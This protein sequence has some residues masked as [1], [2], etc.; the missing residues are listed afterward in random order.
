MI[1]DLDSVKGS[2]SV[3]SAP[4]NT[5]RAH[6]ILPA[7]RRWAKPPLDFGLRNAH[8]AAML[9]VRSIWLKRILFGQ[10]GLIILRD[11][12]RRE[13]CQRVTVV[14]RHPF[15]RVLVL[16]FQLEALLPPNKLV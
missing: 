9:G 16:V 6:G 11:N 7:Y 5:G 15:G 14:P 8:F 10:A 12:R 1:G 3:D 4:L 13:P 2:E